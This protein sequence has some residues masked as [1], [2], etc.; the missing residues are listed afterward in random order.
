MAIREKHSSDKPLD[1]VRITGSLHMTVQT[2][3]LI[4]TLAELE[5]QLDGLAV[6]YFYTGPCRSGSSGFWHSCFRLEG[7]CH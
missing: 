6:T 1:G 4:E 7:K 3:V 5:L 2:A